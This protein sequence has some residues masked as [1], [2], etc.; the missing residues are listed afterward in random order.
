MNT[1][2]SAVGFVTRQVPGQCFC[3]VDVTISGLPAGV[4][5]TVNPA[6]PIGA[7]AAGNVP[8]TITITVPAGLPGGD[9][10]YTITATGVAGDCK[11]QVQTTIPILHVTKPPAPAAVV[12]QVSVANKTYDATTAATLTNCTLSGVQAGD[13]VTCS[14]AS[15]SFSDKN[16]GLGK[17]VTAS[18][19]VLSGTNA[20][21]Y[22]LSTTTVTT[23][24]SILQAPLALTAV[25][26]TKD[27]DGNTSAAAVPTVSPGRRTA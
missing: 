2:A 13:L 6:N 1:Q 9:Y 21:K 5:A 12:P 18:G 8:I 11:G 23:Q 24:A 22:T 7:V 15:A 14:A 26:Y 16:A 4:V 20:G 25:A 3:D 17:T 10:P 27:Y 19:I